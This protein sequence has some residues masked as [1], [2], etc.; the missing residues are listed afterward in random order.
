MQI[1]SWAIRNP[2]PVVVLFIALTLAGIVAYV[3]LPVKRYPNI[4]FPIAQITVTQSGAAPPEMEN[5][6]TRPVENAVA[7]VAGVKHISSTVSLGSSVTTVEFELHTDMQRATDDVRTA[8][9]RIRVQMPAGIDAPTVQRVD[10]DNVPIVTYAVS[11]TTLDAAD[12]SWLIDDTIARR[13]QAQRGVARITRVGGVTREINIVLDPERMAAFGV[14]A[15]QVSQALAQFNTDEPGGRAGI[16]GREQTIRVLGSAVTIDRLRQLTIPVQGRYVILSNI[17]EVGDGMSEERGFARLDGRPAIGFQVSKTTDASDVTV[18]D[19][20]KRTLAQI[21]RERPDLHF[22]EV[23]NTVDRTRA[24]FSATVHMLIEGTLLAALV[25][26]VFLRDWRATLI[27]AVAMPLSLIPTFAAMSAMGFSLNSITLLALTLVIGILVDDAIVEVENIQKRIEAGMTPFRAAI[28]GA[29]AIGL[30]VVATTATIIAVFLPVSAIPGE[31][32]QFFREFGL[33]VGV[34]VICSLAVARLLTPLM[35]AYLLVPAK[36]TEVHK[37]AHSRLYMRALDWNLAHPRIAAAISAGVLAA[38]VVIAASLPSGFQPTGNPDFLYLQLQGPPGATRTSME[39]AVARATQIL[40]RQAD[41]SGVFAQVGSSTGGGFGEGGASDAGSGTITVM[42]RHDRKRT[43]EEVKRDIRPLLRAVPDIRISNQGDFGAAPIEI[44]LASE[45]GTALAMVQEQLMRQ[46]RGLSVVADPRPLPPPSSPE[47]VITPRPAEAAR[48]NVDSRLL[49]QV[50]RVATIGD[51]DANVAKL[52]DGARRVPIRARLPES[53]RN[54]LATLS[55]L[56]VPTLNGQTTSLSA[57]ADF[58]FGAGPAQITRYD[59]ER[60]ANVDADLAP[61][62]TI[63]QAL[64][65]I[66]ALPVMRHLPA[67]VREAKSGSIEA[68]GELFGG[69]AI[70]IVAGIGLTF[71]VLVLLFRSFF[72]PVV[73]MAA[74]PLSLLGAFAALWIG[75]KALDLPALIGLLLLLGLCAKNSI[76]L[77]ELAIE[78]ERA[79][80]SMTQALRN[81]CAERARPIIMTTFAMGAGMLPTALGAGE[82][83][84]FRQPM[85]MAVIGGLITS[86]VLS[87]LLVPVAYEIVDKYEKRITGL[88]SRLLPRQVPEPEIVSG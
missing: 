82:G 81:A 20:V 39:R 66:Y 45:D 12:L 14:T 15:P 27:A 73:I 48:L 41:V 61:G 35:A 38:A 88:F 30:A 68:M 23:L 4:S 47:L 84:E 80:R 49:A 9:E 40:R 33:T 31:S 22:T 57:V 3:Q 42:L 54:D 13:L 58:K 52:N 59:R 79:G 21:G 43:V 53:A 36:S 72:K 62:A 75:D 1:S 18:D 8:V 55:Q 2:I 83:S 56:Q 63:G 51:I 87:L 50:L 6:I 70:A 37:T 85:A 19:S 26:F 16:G 77:V 7:G 76:L 17:A 46:M 74:L 28:T 5:Q 32:G 86:T 44:V 65:A 11:S 67:G 25:V 34:A 10:V 29:D 69:F 60:R 78:E 71:G 64:K 24:N